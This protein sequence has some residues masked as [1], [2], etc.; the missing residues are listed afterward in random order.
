MSA[1]RMLTA[2]ESHGRALVGIL[3]GMPA[4]V[5]IDKEKIDEQLCR[6]QIGLGRGKRMSIESD[7]VQILSGL[8]FGKTLGSPVALLIENK[9]WPNWEKRMS[10]T[11]GDDADPVLIP[12][13]GHADYAGAIKYDHDDM[14]NVLER[15]SARETAV[16]VALGSVVRQLLELF[17]VWIGGHVVQIG[18]VENI[19]TFLSRCDPMNE[20]SERRI[21]DAFTRAEA[22][23]VRCGDAE[24]EKRMTDL[25]REA[26]KAGDSLGGVFEVVALNP[27]IGLGS[28]ASWD[29][30]LD[31]RLSYA[32][33]SIPGIKSV[34][35]GQGLES[36][37]LRGSKCHDAFNVDGQGVVSRLSNRAGG[38]EGGV[39]NGQPI[40]VRAAMK[41]IPTLKKPLPSFHWIERKP[42]P[43]HH[44]RSDVCAVPAASVVGEAVLAMELGSAFCE[45]FGGDSLEQMKRHWKSHARS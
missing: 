41:P 24:S 29:R 43:A 27:P 39:T 31:A 34:E 1:L 16:R 19:H 33:M 5:P 23:P 30:R 42:V 15:A 26:E 38:I 36:A 35:I 18:P 2:G 3:D 17:N 10:A 14:R 21:R 45:R 12:R 7:R 40:L 44:E 25:V 22:S 37:R 9:D 28:Y 8:R 11:S 20:Q 13:P 6:R 32:F 4:G